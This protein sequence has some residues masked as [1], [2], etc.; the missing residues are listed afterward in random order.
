MGVALLAAVLAACDVP[1]GTTIEDP[2]GRM[3]GVTFDEAAVIQDLSDLGL[4]ATAYVEQILGVA[5]AA[6]KGPGAMLKQ[7]ESITTLMKIAKFTEGD[8]LLIAA[9]ADDH[10]C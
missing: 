7:Q 2:F 8:F 1:F 10:L 5:H 6:C 3:H 9:A 4:P